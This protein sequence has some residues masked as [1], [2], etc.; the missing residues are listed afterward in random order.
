MN[1][2]CI[3]FKY[4]SKHR[5]IHVFSFCESKKVPFFSSRALAGRQ[6]AGARDLTVCLWRTPTPSRCLFSRASTAASRRHWRGCPSTAWG[7]PR[8][9]RGGRPCPPGCPSPAPTVPPRRKWWWK[10]DT[11]RVKI[12]LSNGRDLYLGCN[13]AR[14]NQSFGSFYQEVFF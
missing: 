13:L 3:P 14:Q 4:L 5:L 9:T 2:R 7:L 6:E 1:P 11:N 10:W 12:F 8:R